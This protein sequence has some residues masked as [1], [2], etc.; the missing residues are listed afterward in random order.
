MYN[1]IDSKHSKVKDYDPGD[2][3]IEDLQSPTNGNAKNKGSFWDVF[4]FGICLASTNLFIEWDVGLVNGYWSFFFATVFT[5]SVFVNLHLCVA[6]MVSILPFS[7]G[8]YGFTRVT[9]GPYA[10]FLVGCLESIANI[11][12][13][14]IAMIPIGTCITYIFRSNP[15]Y[16]PLYWF[17]AYMAVLGLECLGRQF[18]FKFIRTYAF[19]IIMLVIYYMILATENS[20]A[21]DYIPSLENHVFP[22]GIKDFLTILPTA[23]WFFLSLEIMPLVSDE[24]HRVRSIFPVML[25]SLILFIGENGG[26]KGNCCDID[27]Y[28]AMGVFSSNLCC[29]SISWSCR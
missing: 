13:S 9:V 1:T 8:M 11:V 26:T 29:I 28:C 3:E 14:L 17:L 27:S 22:H 10:G 15:I 19:V 5:T 25:H 16:E 12:Y 20:N 2:F 21:E 4:C 24:V 18:Y 6:E 7:G 23:G